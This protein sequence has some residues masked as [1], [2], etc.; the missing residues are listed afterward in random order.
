M[1]PKVKSNQDFLR[2]VYKGPAKARKQA[3][4]SATSNQ[5]KALCECAANA[6]SGRLIIKPSLR[7]QL[8]A[9][10][11]N[12][13]RLA[14]NKEPIE[15]KKRLLIQSGGALPVLAALGL[16]ALGSLIPSIFGR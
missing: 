8:K 1:A 11:A 4:V 10:E 6:C 5:I 16:S 12:L 14:Y 2:K 15:V 7:K 13:I 9:K 3:V